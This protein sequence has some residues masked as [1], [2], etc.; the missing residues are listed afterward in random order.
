M[1]V[2]AAATL[3]ALVLGTLAAFAMRRFRFFGQNS[4]SFLWILPI[5]L[6]GHRHRRRPAEQLRPHVEHRTALVPGR[7]RLPLPRHRPRHVL[8]RD[9]L[10]QRHRPP[11]PLVAEPAR[12]V[13][14]PRRP[15][16]P[17]VPLRHVPARPFGARRRR[18]SSPSPSA[19]TRSSSP[20]SR[21][22]PATRR[23]RSGS[24][25]TSAGRTTCRSSTSMATFV[26]AVSIPLAWLAQRLSDGR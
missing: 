20:R 22:V 19:S 25:P 7:I 23:C 26:M 21:P 12:G 24:S 18:A 11:P 2:A 9:R 16:G 15:A 3:I 5:A 1:K 14:R 10:Q 8:R 6:P 4:L 17:D 13:G